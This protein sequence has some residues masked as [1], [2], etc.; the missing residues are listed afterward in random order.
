[1]LAHIVVFVAGISCTEYIVVTGICL[2]YALAGRAVVAD[3]TPLVIRAYVCVII[4]VDALV[5]GT[6]IV[7]TWVVVVALGILRALA[8][9]MRVDADIV[10]FVAGIGRTGD[11]VVAVSLRAYALA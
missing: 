7:C 8:V 5:V 11:I 2:A 3:G 6:V 4:L 9:G 1:V 10:A